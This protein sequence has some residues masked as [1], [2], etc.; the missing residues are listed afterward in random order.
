MNSLV[1]LRD[2]STFYLF[3]FYFYLF[4]YSFFNSLVCTGDIYPSV[5]CVRGE[6][7]VIGE[8]SLFPAVWTV[9][10]GCKI[11]GKVFSTSALQGTFLEDR[12]LLILP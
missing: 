3:I 2:R 6:M 1:L 5:R 9:E 7:F 8:V 4:I 11:L 10:S 12:L